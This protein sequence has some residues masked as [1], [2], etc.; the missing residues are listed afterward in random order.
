MSSPSV[1]FSSVFLYSGMDLERRTDPLLKCIG[2]KDV[3]VLDLVIALGVLHSVMKLE[4]VLPKKEH[5][6]RCV[7][8]LW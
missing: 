7:R 2:L 3:R 6:M 1:S 8:K 5:A 4:M